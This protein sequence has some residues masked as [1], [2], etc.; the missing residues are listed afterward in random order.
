MPVSTY[1]VQLHAGFGFDDAAAIVPYL[2][3]LGI[4]HLYCSPCLQA[5]PGSTH[6][7]DVVDHGRLGVELGGEP[8]HA[9]LVEACR[10]A[11]L[12]IVLDIVPNH[13]AVPVPESL[14]PAWWDVLRR[15]P[16]SPYAGW[17]DI[18][19][20]SPS[21]LLVPVLGDQL[22]ACLDRGE[23]RYDD[24]GGEP[25]I[26]YYDHALPVAPGTE[27][28]ANSPG[29][30]L[31][32]LLDAQHYRLCHW[33][34]AA[35]ELNYRRF[36]DVTTLA[37]VRVE[38]PEVF[39]A[40]HE[41]VLAQLRAGVLDGLRIDHPDGLADPAAYL[42]RLA[43]AT[44]G[45][46]VAVEKILE[47]GEELP[48][49]WRCAGTTGYDALNRLTGLLVDP[50][51][52]SALTAVYDELAGGP[53]DYAAVVEASK[54]LV[55]T[56]VLGAE[57]NRLTEVAVRI[58]RL[59]PRH[60]DHTRRALH[61]ALVE[62]L[63]AFDVYR[64]DVR[65][66][67]P[68]EATARGQ[69]EQ[70]AA[71]ARMRRPRRAAEINLIQ[72]LA[73]GTDLAAATGAA[74]TLRTDFCVR[75]QQTCGPVMA[76]GAE[77]TAC[78]RYHRLV[79]LNEVG[80]D[81]GR[82]GASVADF[83]TAGAI[84]QRDWPLTM[85]TLSTHD[86]KRAE[87]VRARLAVLSEVP[88]QWAQAVTGWMAL[89]ERYRR[90]GL[91]D[92]NTAYLLFQTLVGAWPLPADRLLAY[93]EKASREAKQRTSWTDPDPAYDG[94][95]AAYARAVC[96]DEEI[97]AG[98]GEFVNLVA[99]M[100]RTNVLGQKLLQ[101]TM[102]GVADVYQGSELGAWS[103]VDPDNRRPVDYD[104]RAALLA[105]L[106]LNP[107]AELNLD[108]AKLLVVSRALRLRRQHPDWFGATSTYR[109]LVATGTRSKHV[110]AFARAESVIAVVSRLTAEL[111]G[112]WGDT[113]LE[114]PAGQWRDA[115]A[116]RALADRLAGEGAVELA[117]LLARSPVAL[118]VRH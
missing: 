60:R 24:G 1:R 65:P 82:F 14:N 37:G 32:A 86:T 67:E 2:A 20:H 73:L 108:A 84:A 7:Y 18:Y 109:P 44:G 81:P 100:T 36:F 99:P 28:L 118:L 16:H 39:A 34:V 25:V 103:L 89:A 4:T 87:D 8:A 51:G 117:D 114:L 107:A 63:V 40:T 59:D 115:L 49:S 5:A 95:L 58:C 53:T 31:L 52:E 21:P 90:G 96:A 15:G 46:W 45:A 41:L 43:E 48:P 64:A 26:R 57:V 22:G 33:R 112:D 116:D 102:P 61:E 98:V 76:K 56:E 42:D 17:F 83:H 12:G 11:G 71:R 111:G 6:G 35:E 19:P 101:L 38:R 97:T 104:R 85:T 10:A 110:V 50:A 94:A 13:M 92:R 91:P 27:A 9:R 77:D 88:A 69:I 93:L 55:V 74:R 79:A 68:V 47:V 54:R 105:S 3:D 75:F 23:V 30:D 113:A 70:A 29:G 72:D 106:D 80:G 62:T 66:G 78:Y